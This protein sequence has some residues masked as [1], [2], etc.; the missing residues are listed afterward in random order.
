MVTQLAFLVLIG[1]VSLQRVAELFL[2]ARNAQTLQSEGAIEFGRQ[3]YPMMVLLH[4][5][6]LVSCPL[7]VLLFDRPFVP[8]LAALM[9][10]LLIAAQLLRWWTIRVLGK[11][12]TTRV[13]AHPHEP[14]IAAGPYRLVRHPNYLA[15]VIEIA[16]IPLIHS[17]WVTAL[18]FSLL[19][20]WM[21][22]VR[23]AAETKA[24]ALSP[25]RAVSQ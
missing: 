16:S 9:F 25:R 5:G 1:L 14:L 13:F 24:L 10:G 3:H 6:F 12:W 22:K 17:A 2:S 11:R 23:I 20:G 7:E 18:V 21:L 15:V 19:N 4:I 8:W